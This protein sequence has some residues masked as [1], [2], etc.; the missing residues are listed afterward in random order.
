[1]QESSPKVS[2]LT[3]MISKWIQHLPKPFK[4]FKKLPKLHQNQIEIKQN[5]IWD[6]FWGSW[7]ARLVP[8][9]SSAKAANPKV[10]FLFENCNPMTDF[11]THFGIKIFPISMQ[12]SM[13]EKFWQWWHN[14]R[15]IMK[16]WFQS[17]CNIG[18]L[19]VK[20][21]FRKTCFQHC[22]IKV[23]EGWGSQ[24]S[25]NNQSKINKKSMLEKVM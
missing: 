14:D 21:T 4:I 12:K 7:S 23:F 18:A 25:I 6:G 1:M 16:K 22:F 20:L 11:G 8:G 24:K 2:K 19:S 15:Q 3:K 9:L 10:D 5:V 17:R 13:P